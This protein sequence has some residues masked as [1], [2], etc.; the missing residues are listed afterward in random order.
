M[1]H[2]AIRLAKAFSAGEEVD[3]V[4]GGYRTQI[5][6]IDNDVIRVYFYKYKNY[7]AYFCF[8]IHK[9]KFAVT[10]EVL[11]GKRPK[12]DGERS[13]KGTSRIPAAIWEDWARSNLAHKI[14]SAPRSRGELV[15]SPFHLPRQS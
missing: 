4:V 5:V 6:P 3:S 2:Q 14:P 7:E 1:D 10:V 15:M 12:L 8:D 9:L 13:G 11:G